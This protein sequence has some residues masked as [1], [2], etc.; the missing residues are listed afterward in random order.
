M[1]RTTPSGE[2]AYPLMKPRRALGQRMTILQTLSPP[3]LRKLK[4]FVAE[5]GTSFRASCRTTCAGNDGN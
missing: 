5:I 4:R 2:V 3:D 1:G